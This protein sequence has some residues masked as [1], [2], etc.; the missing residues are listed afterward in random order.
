MGDG[1]Y[2]NESEGA[3]IQM[4]STHTQLE[5]GHKSKSAFKQF[6][7]TPP[8]KRRR[9]R[10]KGATKTKLGRPQVTAPTN[11]PSQTMIDLSK[12]SDTIDLTKKHKAE[13]DARIEGDWATAGRT[14]RQ[15]INWDVAPNSALRLRIADSWSG[16]KD[17]YKDGQSFGRFCKTMGIDRNVLKRFLSGKYLQNLAATNKPR[18]R[19]S[20]LNKNVM[21]H[22]CEGW[23]GV[24]F[25]LY[26]LHI[27]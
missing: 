13:L 8:L 27:I 26:C 3:T 22:L 18:G 4:A 16:K 20:L 7:D 6:F 14:K 25:L 5:Y 17:L 1:K 2:L 10:P 24:F 15:R 9:G 11:T 23:F 21:R 12:E 19:P